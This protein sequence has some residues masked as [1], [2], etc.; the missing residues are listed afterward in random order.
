MDDK[1]LRERL[2]LLM[3]L[4]K[5]ILRNL[6]YGPGE[7]IATSNIAD[8]IQRSWEEI[9]IKARKKDTDHG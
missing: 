8:N 6:H 2:N 3:R 7:S 9:E 1:E 5:A 4:G